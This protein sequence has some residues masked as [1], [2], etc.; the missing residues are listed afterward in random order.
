M[1]TMQVCEDR[2]MDNP[3]TIFPNLLV[4]KKL[5]GPQGL[6]IALFDI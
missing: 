3:A 4:F 5:F 1:Y 6:N 2:T